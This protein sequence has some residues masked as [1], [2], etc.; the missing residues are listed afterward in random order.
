MAESEATKVT[1]QAI[2][3]FIGKSRLGTIPALL[4]IS[5]VLYYPALRERLGIQAVFLDYEQALRVMFLLLSFIVLVD[6]LAFSYKYF[7]P[8]IRD[9]LTI[10]F[11]HK[12]ITS[13]L[14]ADKRLL[15]WMLILEIRIPNF[16]GLDL[17]ML[18]KRHFVAREII[19]EK[20]CYA[21]PLGL[22]EYMVRHRNMILSVTFRKNPTLPRLLLE[23]ST[24]VRINQSLASYL[25]EHSTELG[26]VGDYTQFLNQHIN[27]VGQ[28]DPIEDDVA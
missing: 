4:L 3:S 26:L 6:I 15:C 20:I 13:L 24:H 11:L 27:D 2:E 10:V 22:F 23:N 8:V 18:A 1:L 25:A 14:L 7:I 5:I 21:I 16:N 9:I 17:A 12:R 28:P 19:N